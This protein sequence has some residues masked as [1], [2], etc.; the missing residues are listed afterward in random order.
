LQVTG[1]ETVAGGSLIAWGLDY[2]AAAACPECRTIS[3]PG[4]RRVLIG[5]SALAARIDRTGR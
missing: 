5:S 4:A 1:A 3:G 2:P